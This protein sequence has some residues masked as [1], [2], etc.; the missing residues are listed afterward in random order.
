MKRVWRHIVAR[1]YKPVLEK[2]LSKT[3][4]YRYGSIRLEV[5]PSVFHPGFFFTSRL[6]LNYVK[7]IPLTGKSLLEPG[8]GSG[9]L[10]IYA[11]R[12]GATVTA[13]DINPVATG[14]L[15]RNCER[16]SVEMK[17]I[18]SD[19]FE[20]IPAQQFDIITINPPFYKKEPQTEK[21]HAWYCGANGE[22]FEKLFRQL[23]SYM[24]DSSLVLMVLFDGCDLEMIYKTAATYGFEFQCMVKSKNLLENDFIFKIVPNIQ[25]Q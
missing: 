23:R 8:C 17:I 19:L 9:L 18:R 1:T 2:Y 5:A 25:M 15:R 21:D 12:N 22:F 3:R 13:T 16:N 10:S 6:L 14:M 24:H 20:K 7:G 11:A 4:T